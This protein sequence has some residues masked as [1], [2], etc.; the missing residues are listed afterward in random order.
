MH[1]DHSPVVD[2]AVV[3]IAVVAYI[4]A[5]VGLACTVVDFANTVG[6]ADSSFTVLAHNYW[7][8]TKLTLFLTT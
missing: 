6:E 4:A 3:D 2:I 8:D 7:E 1:F 5:A